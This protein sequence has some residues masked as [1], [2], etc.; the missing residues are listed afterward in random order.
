MVA[1]TPSNHSPHPAMS[2]LRRR[3]SKLNVCHGPRTG[4]R[5]RT[6]ACAR[7]L[8]QAIVI[9]FKA[10][11]KNSLRKLSEKACKLLYSKLTRRIACAR[12]RSDSLRKRAIFINILPRRL[13]YTYNY[14]LLCRNS[15]CAIK[16]SLRKLACTR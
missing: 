5:P 10:Y 1:P 4:P 12:S 6:K 7:I 14:K 11:K 13:T 8:A 3:Y 2:K 9:V 16:D 15:S